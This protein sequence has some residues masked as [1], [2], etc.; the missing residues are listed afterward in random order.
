MFH[1]IKEFTLLLNLYTYIGPDITCVVH[2][3]NFN[4]SNEED[5][6]IKIVNTCVFINI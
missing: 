4:I 3:I 5:I 1:N 6:K 2:D